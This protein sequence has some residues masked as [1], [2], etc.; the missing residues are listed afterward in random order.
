MDRKDIWVDFGLS[1]LTKWYG[2]TFE[3]T[4]LEIAVDAADWGEGAYAPTLREDALRLLESPLPT[5]VIDILS[6]AAVRSKFVPEERWMDGRD[7]LRQIVDVCEERIRRDEPR[8]AAHPPVP[9]WGPELRDAVLAEVRTIATE[10][11]HTTADH[12]YYAV[13]EV[14]PSLERVVTEVD[15]DLGFR[16]FLR[17]LKAYLIPISDSQHLRY[18]ELGERFGY[19]EFVV[20]DGTLQLMPRVD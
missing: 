5:R 12:P 10:L 17:V 8:F 1:G 3:F 4:P 2:S 11:E 15:P 13:P 7:W 6:C 16:L 19:N 18:R 14:V 9:A 20:D